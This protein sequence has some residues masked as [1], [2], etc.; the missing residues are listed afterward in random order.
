MHI[1]AFVSG[2][3]AASRLDRDSEGWAHLTK[4]STVAALERSL[5]VSRVDAV[6]FEFTTDDSAELEA[7]VRCVRRDYPS[8]PV[9]LYCSVTADAMR[10]ILR[11]ARAG[12]DEV[13]LEGYD[14]YRQSLQRL[15]LS[16][17]RSHY[18]SRSLGALT[19]HLPAGTRA[20]LARSLEGADSRLTVRELAQD[21]GVSRK[22]L[23]NRLAASGLP[24]PASLISRCRLLFAC[25]LLEDPARSVEQVAL[26]LGFGSGVA[27]RN[28]FRRYVGLAP[29]EVRRRDAFESVARRLLLME[30]SSLPPG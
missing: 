27:L 10:L 25:E 18:V 2:L 7:T 28:M 11:L 26:L 21:I 17:Y 16:A 6:V 4:V 9:I 29:S 3:R 24:G 23:L 1:L 30:G 8:V 5:V 20:I 22:T 13:I 14:D 15:V 12:I 19:T